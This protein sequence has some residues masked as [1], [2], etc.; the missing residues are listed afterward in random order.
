M[1]ARKRSAG[2]ET[3]LSK[4]INDALELQGCRVIRIQSGK[5]KVTNGKRTYWVH[6]AEKGTPDRLVIRPG[7]PLAS[8]YAAIGFI[9]VKAA[10][11][12]LNPEQ[13]KWHAWAKSADVNCAVVRTVAE[14]LS[15]VSSWT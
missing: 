14:A 10:N 11:G 15:A 5:L 7:A 6:M 4:A 13:R 9:E 1:T 2:S 3:A 8:G 12:K